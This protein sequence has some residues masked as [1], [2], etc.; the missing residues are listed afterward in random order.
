M[1]DNSFTGSFMLIFL[2][3]NNK[4]YLHDLWVISIEVI[5]VTVFIAFKYVVIANIEKIIIVK[6]IIIKRFISIFNI[7][8]VNIEV[9]AA[10]IV[11]IIKSKKNADLVGEFQINFPPIVILELFIFINK[12]ECNFR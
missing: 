5:V 3:L 9:K 2:I 12:R 11:D 10:I 8:K 1:C 6:T 4:K 7:E